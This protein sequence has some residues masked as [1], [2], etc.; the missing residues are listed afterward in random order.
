MDTKERIL[1]EGTAL[2]KKYG[3]RSVTMD[4]IARELSISKKTIYQFFKDKDEVVTLAMKD[5][6]EQEKEEYAALIDVK[7]AVEELALITKC[8]LEDLDDINPSLIFDLQKYHP[9]AWAIIKEFQNNFLRKAVV[10]NIE[11]GIKEGIFRDGLD[12]EVLAVLRVQQ[13]HMACDNQLFPLDKFSIYDTHMKLF[14]HYINGI[15]T[16]KGK[17]YYNNFL[18]QID[19]PTTNHY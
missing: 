16:E 18:R 10:R 4:D 9:K 13:I 8:I 2:F 15:V 5:F 11:N 17:E 7:N 1:R 6:I 19:I 14:D 12:P 3:V